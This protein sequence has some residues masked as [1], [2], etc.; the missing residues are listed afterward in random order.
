MRKVSLYFTL[1]ISHIFPEPWLQPEPSMALHFVPNPFFL[2][3]SSTPVLKHPAYSPDTVTFYLLSVPHLLD[4]FLTP[5][6][7]LC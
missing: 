6:F 3:F 7:C 4:I 2:A 5:C 1:T